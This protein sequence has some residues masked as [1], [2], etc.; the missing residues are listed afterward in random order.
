MR[1]LGDRE[2]EADALDLNVS[3]IAFQDVFV[4]RFSPF[5]L[6]DDGERLKVESP[7]WRFSSLS[8]ISEFIFPFSRIVVVT[9]L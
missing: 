1:F 5:Y 7:I 2:E 8:G 3:P 4:G 9:L 6:S